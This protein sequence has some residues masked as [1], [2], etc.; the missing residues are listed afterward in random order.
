MAEDDEH[1]VAVVGQAAQ[2]ALGRGDVAPGRLRPG[3]VE[4][5]ALVALHEIDRHGVAQKAAH[6]DER[7]VEALAHVAGQRGRELGIEAG[8][9]A[10]DVVGADARQA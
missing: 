3:G 4:L 10:D 7:Q 5:Q 2:V 1:P 6:L 8:E 9:L